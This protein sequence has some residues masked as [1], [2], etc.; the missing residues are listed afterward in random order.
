[1][2]A[3]SYF[4]KGL[5]QFKQGNKE[6]AKNYFIKASQCSDA[7]DLKHDWKHMVHENGLSSSEI[8]SFASRF[9][10][11]RGPGGVIICSIL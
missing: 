2:S 4:Q 3:S 6:E 10:D 11:N 7:D 9:L 5:K 1:M 8:Q